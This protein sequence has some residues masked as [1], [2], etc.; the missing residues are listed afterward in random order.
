MIKEIMTMFSYAFMQ[1]AFIVGTLIAF[2]AS[3]IG[4]CLVL[5]RNS[6]IGDGL[7]HVGFG[8]FALATILGI[9]KLEFALPVVIVASVFVLKMNDHSKISGDAKIALLSASALALGTF[10]I[11]IVQGVNNDIN[12]YLFG[13]ILATS[14]LDVVISIILSLIVISLY[15]FSYHKIFALTF[16]ANFAKSIGIKTEW[17][18]FVFALL[19]SIVVVLGLRLMGSLLISS[20]LIFPTV[21]AMQVFKKFKTV[22]IFS[23]II[24]LFSFI[25]GLTFSYLFSLPTG[26]TIVLVNLVIFLIFKLIS[27]FRR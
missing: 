20:L 7:S 13:S 5:K 17:Y 10:V 22:V 4:V 24:S 12:S 26:A 23:T 6:M 18:N 11:S 27:I 1:R 21:S 19:C 15:I 16:D 14:N 8:A 25:F 9:S 3:L 2:S